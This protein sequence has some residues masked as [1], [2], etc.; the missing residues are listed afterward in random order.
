MSVNETEML[1]A[2]SSAIE[3]EGEVP[4]ETTDAETPNA[5]GTEDAGSD[6]AADETGSDPAGDDAD[7][8]GDGGE[9]P[10]GDDT[11]KGGEGEGESEG[12]DADPAADP[13]AKPTDVEPG[14]EAPAKDPINDPLPAGLKEATRERIVS[15]IDTAKTLTAR[16]ER[17]EQQYSELMGVIQESSATPE[18]YGQALDYIRMV[19]SGDPQQLRRCIAYV[20]GELKA[21]CKLAGVA[22]PGV[23]LL[24]EFPDLQERVAKGELTQDAAEELAA[25]RGNQQVRASHAQHTT[26]LQQR[27]AVVNA[28]IASL[29]ELEVELK[30][31]DPHFAY[32]REILVKS[33]RPVF[34]QIDP[35]QWKATFLTAYNELPNPVATARPT[36]K[37][38][39]PTN[40]PLR[41]RNPAGKPAAAPASALD[42][43]NAGLENLGG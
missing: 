13:Q 16:A 43:L 35:R 22:V 15:L 4:E 21:L 12:A 39:I 5:G 30:S 36:P 28:G 24:D 7:A 3:N 23:D 1:A 9:P 40:Q 26:Q 37:P 41:A 19:N 29:N 25:A 6:P 27:Q 38:N 2:L 42:A 17:A 32:K 34:A 18:Q 33:L 20:Q 31:K 8:G 10:A 14:K 11:D